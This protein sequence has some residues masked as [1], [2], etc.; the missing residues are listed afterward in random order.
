MITRDKY[1]GLDPEIAAVLRQGKKHVK[2]WYWDDC[3]HKS[4]GWL[5][6]YK[7]TEDFPYKIHTEYN[8]TEGFKNIEL[9][10]K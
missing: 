1:E 5:F 7:I 9:Y 4:T 2:V 6:D 3:R 10:E 8:S